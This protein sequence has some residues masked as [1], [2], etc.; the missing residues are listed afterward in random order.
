MTERTKRVQPAR[1]R[2]SRDV[3]R[4]AAAALLAAVVAAGCSR[5]ERSAD[6]DSS[7]EARDTTA[8][9]SLAAEPVDRNASHVT[10]GSASRAPAPRASILFIGTSLTAGYGLDSP[11]QAYPA[12]V[13]RMLDS[14]GHPA[15]VINLG[16]SGETSAGARARIDWALRNPADVVV[17][18]TGANDGLRGLSVA[19]AR[20]N[21]QTIL[22]RIRVLRPRARV[23]LVQM[24][25]LPNLGARYTSDFHAMFPELARKNGVELVPFL[26]E[27]VAGNPSLN[28]PDG[29]HPNARGA[30]IAARTVYDALVR[31]PLVAND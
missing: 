14:A 24:E 11:D 23:L 31:K 3:A 27:G 19:A 6:V 2:W 13:A 9:R 10:N 29:I 7:A 25:A 12:I 17:V 15:D 22:D 20:E 21:I 30:R 18:E 26:L 5:D 8:D 4:A 28:Q 16:V 1:S